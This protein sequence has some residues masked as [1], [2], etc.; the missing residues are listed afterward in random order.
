MSEVNA[1][2]REV[3]TVTLSPDEAKF[4]RD[5]AGL[6]LPGVSAEA[7]WANRL[8]DD[9]YDIYPDVEEANPFVVTKTAVR[10]G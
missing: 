6:V 1:E 2:T 9:L 5:L 4:L 8:F 3:V 7:M 10:A